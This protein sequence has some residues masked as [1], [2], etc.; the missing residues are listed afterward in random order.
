MNGFRAGDNQSVPTAAMLFDDFIYRN[1]NMTQ[2]LEK[3]GKQVFSLTWKSKR[4]HHQMVLWYALPRAR[5]QLPLVERILGPHA[6]EIVDRT[7]DR[8][9]GI[10]LRTELSEVEINITLEELY[11]ISLVSLYIIS[12]ISIRTVVWRKALNDFQKKFLVPLQSMLPS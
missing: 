6:R 8:L 1:P 9:K 7:T 11:C 4:L 2:Y 12:E 10:P 3:F 5:R